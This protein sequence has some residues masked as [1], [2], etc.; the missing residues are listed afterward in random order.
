MATSSLLQVA[1]THRGLPQR[2]PL[3]A[4][5][6]VREQVRGGFVGPVEV[7]E[8]EDPRLGTAAE[9][10]YNL[11]DGLE[12]AGLGAG[13]VQRGRGRQAGPQGGQLGKQA[14]GL[15]DPVPR[16]LVQPSV[17]AGSAADGVSEPVDEWPVGQTGLAFIA[18][19]PD[20]SGASGADLGQKLLGQASLADARLSLQHH[21]MAIAADRPIGVQ[22]CL[23]LGLAA[24]QGV[25]GWATGGSRDRLDMVRRHGSGGR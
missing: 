2:P 12:E 14:D 17:G 9:R 1:T 24:H 16:Y 21:Q 13:T 10:Q 20:G 23:P 11:A 8:E 25:V 19:G 7:V 6:Q 22:H 5:H 3:E 18:T 4:T 15:G